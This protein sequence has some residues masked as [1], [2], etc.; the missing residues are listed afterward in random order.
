MWSRNGRRMT[1][2]EA[3]KIL[4][5]WLS[6]GTE[7]MTSDKLGYIEEWFGSADARAFE[8]AI[9]ALEYMHEDWAE[10]EE[11]CKRKESE[12]NGKIK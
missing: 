9:M 10:Y 7:G 11:Y 8:M 6:K 5:C 4:K 2:D 3:I 1:I 12:K